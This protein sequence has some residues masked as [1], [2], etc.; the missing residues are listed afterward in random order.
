MTTRY[1][2]LLAICL[3][4]ALLSLP[5]SSGTILSH[6]GRELDIATVGRGN[7]CVY[8]HKSGEP[9]YTRCGNLVIDLNGQLAVK[10]DNTEWTIDPPIQI[11]NEWE[12]IAVLADG[13]VQTL[14]SGVWNDVG[15]LHLAVFTPTPTFNDPLAVNGYSDD[16]GPPSL[17]PPGSVAGVIQ[18]G[19]LEQRPSTV[20]GISIRILL[21]IL[22]AGVLSRCTAK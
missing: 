22:A 2:A 17:H 8:D 21:A 13:R 15:G 19:W 1:F 18:Q 4:I 20:E 10:V 16:T 6:T 12:R 5:R 11:P 7:F 9:R 14:Q 3:A